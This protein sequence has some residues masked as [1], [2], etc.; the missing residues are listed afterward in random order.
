MERKPGKWKLELHLLLYG[1]DCPWKGLRACVLS[2]KL[3]LSLTSVPNPAE[4]GQC[5]PSA[6]SASS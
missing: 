4:P 1:A 3:V 2:D 6:S 5:H